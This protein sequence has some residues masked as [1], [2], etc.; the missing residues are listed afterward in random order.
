MTSLSLLF[1][2]PAGN[3]GRGDRI[4]ADTIDQRTGERCSDS[5]SRTVPATA[6]GPACSSEHAGKRRFTRCFAQYGDR[7]DVQTTVLGDNNRCALATCAETSSITTAFSW[8]LRL[9]V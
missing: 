2:K 4:S 7:G 3:L 5:G 6:D 1:A 9:T 8:R